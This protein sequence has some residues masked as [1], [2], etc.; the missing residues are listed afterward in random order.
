L[1]IEKLVAGYQSINIHLVL[2]LISLI[3]QAERYNNEIGICQILK[4]AYREVALP[5]YL[6]CVCQIACRPII[7]IWEWLWQFYLNHISHDETN[8]FNLHFMHLNTFLVEIKPVKA[9]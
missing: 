7:P 9:I 1:H 6:Q 3:P 2:I 8:I 5:R 4:V